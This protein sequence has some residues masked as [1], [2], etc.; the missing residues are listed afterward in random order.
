MNTKS[1]MGYHALG[2]SEI[3]DRMVHV[4]IFYESTDI[5]M[6]MYVVI[7]NQKNF[8]FGGGTLQVVKADLNKLYYVKSNN[9]IYSR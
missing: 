9:N 2:S 3:W 8:F 4:V 7:L 5:R 1:R 6:Y